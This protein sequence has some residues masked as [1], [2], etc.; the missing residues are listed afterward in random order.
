MKSRIKDSQLII[1]IIQVYNLKPNDEQAAEQEKDIFIFEAHFEPVY[2]T[3]KT[4]RRRY[5]PLGPVYLRTTALYTCGTGTPRQHS[6][7]TGG[8]R[9][10][11]GSM[12]PVHQDTQVLRSTIWI[13]GTGRPVDKLTT[14]ALWT[15]R[16]PSSRSVPR[17]PP[18]Q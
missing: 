2:G 9:P 8:P 11:Y 3:S 16:P 1:L 18:R 7:G 17:K 15:G 10:H 5:A 4:V 13:D 12:G 6:C 14:A